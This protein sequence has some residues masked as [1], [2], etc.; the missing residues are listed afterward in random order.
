MNYKATVIRAAR[1][2]DVGVVDVEVSEVWKSVNVHGI[3]LPLGRRRLPA[4]AVS[5][6]VFAADGGDMRHCAR[7][8]PTT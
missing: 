7:Q 8:T 4:V 1:T 3:P 2:L 5:A 6:V